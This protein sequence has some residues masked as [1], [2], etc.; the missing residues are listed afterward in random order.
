MVPSAANE[1]RVVADRRE[2][3]G[4]NLPDDVVLITCGV[5]VQDDRF[6]LEVV[7]WGRDEECWSLDYQVI[8]GDPSGTSSTT[9]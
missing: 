4:D 1:T 6:E 8:Y 3:W 7:G 5:D 9:I 2:D